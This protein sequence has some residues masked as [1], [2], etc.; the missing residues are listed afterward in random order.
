V[1][2][3]RAPPLQLCQTPPAVAVYDAR[4]KRCQIVLVLRK[5]LL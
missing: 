2:R 5:F 3:N 4:L 1:R